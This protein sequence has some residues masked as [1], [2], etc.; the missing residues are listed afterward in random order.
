MDELTVA[1]FGDSAVT[2]VAESPMPVV[3]AMRP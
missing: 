3:Y 1:G 2:P